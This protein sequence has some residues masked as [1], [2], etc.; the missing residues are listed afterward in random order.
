[1]PQDGARTGPSAFPVLPVFHNQ[2]TRGLADKIPSARAGDAR[3]IG[4][5]NRASS[6]RKLGQC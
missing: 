6:Q 2:G 1:M 3:V 5:R 4:R